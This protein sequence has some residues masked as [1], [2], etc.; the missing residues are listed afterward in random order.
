MRRMRMHDSAF[1][2]KVAFEAAK[3]EKTISEI[4][5]IYE[6]HP[7]QVSAWKKEFLERLPEIFNDT[8]SKDKKANEIKEERYLKQI[9]QLSVEVEWLKK[10][11]K[12][13]GIKW[14]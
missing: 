3:G 6:V 11:C 1:K 14:E 8:S 9:G 13:L 2:A 5:S 7:N 12:Q 10:K 4:A